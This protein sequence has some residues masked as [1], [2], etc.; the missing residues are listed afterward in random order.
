MKVMKRALTMLLVLTMLL[1]TFAMSVGATETGEGG[2]SSTPINYTITYAGNGGILAE[3]ASS[4]QSVTYNGSYSLASASLFTRPGYTFVGWSFADTATYGNG[5]YPAGNTNTY[6]V[7]GDI[8]FNAVWTPNTYTITYDNGLGQTETQP[9]TYDAPYTLAPATLFTRPGYT[10]KAWK[11]EGWNT[12]HAAGKECEKYSVAQD[13]TF[14]AVWDEDSTTEAPVV[15]PD[16]PTTDPAGKTFVNAISVVKNAYHKGVS[17]DWTAPAGL[18]ADN[19]VLG[20][21][22]KWHLYADIDTDSILEQYNKWTWCA[23]KLDIKSR[24]MMDLVWNGT[25]WKA[26]PVVL[27]VT[28]VHGGCYWGHKHAVTYTDGVAGATIF[29]DVTYYQYGGEYTKVPANPVRPGYRFMGWSPA[30]ATKV[31]GCVTYVAQWAP[32]YG[33]ALT[34][35]HVAYLKGYG[36]G[37]VKPEGEITRAEAITM[38]YRLMD[39]ATI[40]QYYTT[41]NAFTDVAKDAWYNDAVSTMANAGILRYKT[42]LLNPSEKITRAEFFY[43]LAKFS[44]VSYTGK[45]TFVDVPVTYWAYNELTLAQY[46]GWIKGYGGGILNPD[47]T[48]TRAEVAASLNRVLGRTTCKVNDVKKFSDNPTTAWY[49][50]DI[51]EASIGH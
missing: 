6:T 12:E 10:F 26:T 42:G 20:A 14:T 18:S 9:A 5:V 17:F 33:P 15:T 49:Y 13:V 41:Y 36:K 21:D 27:S 35:K 45:C 44:N 43:M 32:A 47:D 23:H 4:S 22:N 31:S 48:I 16:K 24:V 28:C 8:T 46:L 34:T 51:V 7:E 39:E 3:G 50:K 40:K 38:L 11:L 30:V 25:E 37:L 19:A 2:A 1:G 29:S